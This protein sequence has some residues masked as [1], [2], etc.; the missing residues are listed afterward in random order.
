MSPLS[1][2]VLESLGDKLVDSGLSLNQFRAVPQLSLP[3]FSVHVRCRVASSGPDGVGFGPSPQWVLVLAAAPQSP[4][5][6]DFA[7][8]NGGPV[9]SNCGSHPAFREPEHCAELRT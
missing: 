5:A 3:V 7:T 8:A 4:V 6:A 2:T 1:A 9:F